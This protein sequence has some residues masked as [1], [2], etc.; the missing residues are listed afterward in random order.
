MRKPIN[1]N[2]L[3][4]LL[5]GWGHQSNLGS[6]IIR[7]GRDVKDN[8]SLFIL[9]EETPSL[10]VQDLVYK[11]ITN[12]IIKKI[13]NVLKLYPTKPSRSLEYCLWSA[14]HN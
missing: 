7:T 9:N 3:I 6:Q 11:E 12:K 13:S 8:S 5:S 14:S 2:W 10:R 1:K 4:A